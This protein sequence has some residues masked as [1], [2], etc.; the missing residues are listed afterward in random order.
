MKALIKKEL[1]HYLNNPFGYIVI[2]LFAVFA[3]FMFMKDVFVVGQVSM[4]QFFVLLPWIAMVFVPAITMRTLTEE[5]RTNT[6][7]I[8]HTIPLTAMQIVM[9]KFIALV[10][11]AMIALALT[12]GLPVSLNIVGMGAGSTLYL[13]EVLIAYVGVVLFFAMT[14]S[15]SLFLSGG[16][17]NQVVAFL[18]GALALFFLNVIG[19]DMVNSLVPRAVEDVLTLLSPANQLDSFIKGVLDLRSIFYFISTTGIM[20][21]LT[22]MDI[23]KRS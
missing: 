19:T 22:I 18:L 21:F 15:I 1:G 10:L 8:L 4:R 13:P 14:I 9:G 6:I 23:E 20:L 12:L 2:I 3:N 11:V 7:E 17:N 16:T 5:R